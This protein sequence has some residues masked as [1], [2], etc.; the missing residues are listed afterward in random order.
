MKR[1]PTEWDKIFHKELIFEIYKDLTLPNSK[2]KVK[3]RT[4][5]HTHTNQITQLKSRK[6]ALVDIFPK[7]TNK[8][9]KAHER[10]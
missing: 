9:Q 1:Q 7:E 5:T 6:I 8:G 10:C 2:N 3:P 4:H